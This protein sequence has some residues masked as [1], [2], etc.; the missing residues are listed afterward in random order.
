MQV[1]VYPIKST[2]TTHF[3][4]I[5]EEEALAAI[6]ALKAKTEAINREREAQILADKTALS[7]TTEADLTY[8]GNTTTGTALSSGSGNKSGGAPKKKGAK[9]KLTAKEK[10]ERSVRVGS[11][12]CQNI[13]LF[14][15]R[16]R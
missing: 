1:C 7:E 9:P 5:S 13:C 8:A 3:I 10:K 11:F 6:E 14:S 16:L 12:Y 4:F 2:L 15:F